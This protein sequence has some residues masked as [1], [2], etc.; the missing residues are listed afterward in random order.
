MQA[1]LKVLACAALSGALILPQQGA[2]LPFGLQ[3]RQISG[4]ASGSFDGSLSVA[5]PTLPDLPTDVPDL[6]TPTI[7]SLPTDAPD[8]T[9]PTIP[10]L[11][12]DAPDLATPTIRA[13]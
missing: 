10:S 8:L 2:A 6:S 3:A 11:S 4:G 7:S 12:T 5:T 1:F 9:T 13:G